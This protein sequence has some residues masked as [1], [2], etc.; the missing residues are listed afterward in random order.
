MIIRFSYEVI[1]VST[2]MSRELLLSESQITVSRGYYGTNTYF[3]SYSAQYI[4]MFIYMFIFI[5]RF[6]RSCFL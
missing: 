5:T 1:H 4:D 6:T 3:C 2:C